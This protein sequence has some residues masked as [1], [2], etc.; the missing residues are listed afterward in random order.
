M[1]TEIMP[2]PVP[3]VEPREPDPPPAGVTPPARDIRSRAQDPHPSVAEILGGSMSVDEVTNS[4]DYDRFIRALDQME[5]DDRRNVRELAERTDPKDMVK[6]LAERGLTD[7]QAM[8]ALQ[9]MYEGMT[10]QQARELTMADGVRTT[11]DGNRARQESENEEFGE[12]SEARE[13]VANRDAIAHEVRAREVAQEGQ[14]LLANLPQDKGEREVAIE[15][16][17]DKVE[18]IFGK[19]A[20]KTLKNIMKFGTVSMGLFSLLFLLLC[21]LYGGNAK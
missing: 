5:P 9:V 3:P 15:A 10:D 8:R 2:D 17:K 7:G 14:A 16:W 4:E 6:S 21:M 20:T 1:T 11:F 19:N 18:G 12:T 13:E